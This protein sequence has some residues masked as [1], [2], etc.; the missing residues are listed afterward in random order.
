MAA[1]DGPSLQG[2]IEEKLDE[3]A[4]DL[5]DDEDVEEVVSELFDD[6]VEA[7][8]EGLMDHR[9]TM[10]EDWREAMNGFED[11]LYDDWEE[12]IDLFEAFIVFSLELGQM[13][14]RDRQEAAMDD[15]DLVHLVLVK[16]HARACLIARE[17]LTLV[18][19]GYADDAHAR[20]RSIYEVAVVVEF[21]RQT[22]QETAKRFMLHQAIDDY[23]QA[24]AYR[25]E[26]DK[27]RVEPISDETMKE[28]EQWREKLLDHYGSGFDG[29]WG[30]AAHEID[31]GRLKEIEEHA[32]YSQFYPYYKFA[33]EANIHSGAKGTFEQLATT[34]R[35]QLSTPTA[36]ANLGFTLPAT[37]VARSLFQITMALLLH[38][39]NEEYIVQ[40]L[41]PRRLLI[42]SWQ[43]DARRRSPIRTLL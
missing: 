27:L 9:D 20:W 34:D 31:G 43:S 36:P 39:P 22:G 21:I 16:L 15:E 37:H 32:G 12:P 1:D 6:L 30:W 13:Y 2:L 19:H 5:N 29:T 33:S 4:E 40:S 24:V 26:Q 18:K 17:I 3:I 7:D 23:H 11:R 42:S 41:Y 8:F 10:L 35:Y 28:L 38:R 14:S 25:N